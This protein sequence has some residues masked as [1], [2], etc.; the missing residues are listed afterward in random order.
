MILL[1]TGTNDFAIRQALNGLVGDFVNKYG[2]HAVER[3]D[4]EVLDPARL[5]ELL[6]G[7]SLFASIRMVVI[8]DASRNRPLWEALGDWAERVQGDVTLVVQEAAPD[9]RTRTYKQLQKHGQ[10]QDYPEL[11]EYELAKWAVTTSKALGS[12]MDAKVAA[13]LVRQVG[14]NQW[15]LYTELQKLTAAQPTVTTELIDRLVEPNPQASAFEL[16]DAALQGSS[17]KTTGLLA[18]LRAG[19]DPYKLFGL[20]VSQVQ[21]L[22]VVVTA[23][24]KSGEVVAKEAGIHPFVVRKMQPLA[25]TISYP[26]LCGIIASVALA[27]T[28]MKSTGADPWVLLEQCLGKIASRVL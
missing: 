3:F 27:D 15:Q 19:E 6:G 5:S 17:A 24:G 8:R 14:T 26:Q 12:A 16:L 7:I 10:L 28:Q 20:V 4:G 9:K 2:V 25:R 13:H 21:T 11:N 1:L 23:Q 18:K 22:A